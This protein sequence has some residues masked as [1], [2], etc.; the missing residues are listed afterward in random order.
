MSL[1]TGHLWVPSEESEPVT[2]GTS[3]HTGCYFLNVAAT[4]RLSLVKG[5]LL[6]QQHSGRTAAAAAQLFTDAHR[7]SWASLAPK[8]QAHQPVVLRRSRAENLG[9]ALRMLCTDSTDHTSLQLHR[10][11]SMCTVIHVHVL[12]ATHL[13]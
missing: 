13:A 6:E 4:A 1:N 12:N 3:R 9:S 2:V 5:H 7:P 8:E 10:R 11:T